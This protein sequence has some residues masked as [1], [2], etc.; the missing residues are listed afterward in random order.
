MVSAK[1]ILRLIEKGESATLEFKDSRILSDPFKVAKIMTAFANTEG[2]ILLIGIKDDGSIEGMK[3]KKGHE[4]HI[5]NIASEKCDPPLAPRFEKVSIP[6]KGDIYFVQIL[7]KQ[8]PYHAVKTKDGYKFF[9]RVGSTIRER[10]PSQLGLGEQGVEIPAENSL[11]KFWCWLGK[12]ILRKFY[13]ELDANIFKLQLSLAIIGLI[14]I[15]MPLLMLFKFRDGTLFVVNYPVWINLALIGSLTL[16]ILL[17]DWL[18]YI[19]KTR[20]PIC[21]SHFSFRAV[22][23]WVLEKRQIG[24]GLEEWKT[25]TLKRCDKCGYEQPS[26]LQYE[27]VEV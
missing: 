22:K 21:K 20:C 11:E 26:K 12:K 1:Q 2:G 19:P 17:L 10:T 6:N 27:K 24:E 14:L 16:G 18:A 13:G 15:I 8:G 25:R 4:E 9:V 23:K 5:M 3:A 7:E